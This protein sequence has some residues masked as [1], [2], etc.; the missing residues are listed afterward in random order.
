M[1]SYGEFDDKTG[2]APPAVLLGW[3]GLFDDIDHPRYAVAIA[4]FAKAMCPESFLPVHFDLPLCGEM[5]KPALPFCDVL[6]VEDQRES[7]IV[8]FVR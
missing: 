6:R 3:L 2:G 8:G 5:V 7:R 4:D 1:K